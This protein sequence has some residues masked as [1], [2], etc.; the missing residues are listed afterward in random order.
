LPDYFVACDV[1]MFPYDDTLINR[2]KCSVKLIDL[3]AAGLPVVADAVGQN[4]EYIAHGE[5]GLLVGPEDDAAFADAIVSLL[6]GP[7]LRARLG[8]AAARRMREY[9]NWGKLVEE[10][11]KA[12]Q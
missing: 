6:A 11:E 8:D 7:G 10:V 12:Y 3:L 9:F 4:K 1:A 2:A 5:T